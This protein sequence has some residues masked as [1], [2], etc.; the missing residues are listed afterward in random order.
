MRQI[1]F[2]GHLIILFISLIIGCSSRAWT[3]EDEHFVKIYTEILLLRE[4]FP[5]TTNA[6]PKVRAFLQQNGFSEQQFRETYSRYAAR[7][8]R[9]RQLLD[10]ARTRIQTIGAQKSAPASVSPAPTEIR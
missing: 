5:D 6:N 7:P 3:A 2:I 8:E 4:Q 1:P 9:L 10:T